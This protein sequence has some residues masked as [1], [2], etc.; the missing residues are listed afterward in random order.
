GGGVE[1]VGADTIVHPAHA[2]GATDRVPKHGADVRPGHAAHD[3]AQDEA[4][5]TAWYA[6]RRP[7]R[8]VC[9]SC[10]RICTMSSGRSRRARSMTSSGKFGMP[11]RWISTSRI[12]IH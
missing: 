12:V 6:R 3:L 4:A 11:A 8:Q 7:G 10:A 9:G 1:F 2:E 5:V